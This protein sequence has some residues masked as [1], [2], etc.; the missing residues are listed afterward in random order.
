[1]DLLK[2]EV[3]YATLD[4]QDI[5]QLR[6]QPGARAI[7][8]FLASELSCLYP[9]IDNVNP[10]LG[11]FGISVEPATLLV[12]GDRVEIYR[13]LKVDPKEARRALVKKRGP[14]NS[15]AG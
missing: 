4:F 14:Q 5:V 1:M 10:P 12:D 13:G 9:E 2:I 11:I 8:A 6:M 15:G 7:E 3:V